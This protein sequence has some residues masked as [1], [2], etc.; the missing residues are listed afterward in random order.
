MNFVRRLIRLGLR[1]VGNALL[2]VL[3]LAGLAAAIVGYVWYTLP[4]VAELKDRFP[5]VTLQKKGEPVK[6]TIEAKRPAGWT[7]LGEIPRAV[8]GAVVVSEDGTFFQHDG[9]DTDAL[10]AAIKEDLERKSFAFGGSTITQQVVKN[11][12]LQKQKSLIRKAKEFYLA[13]QLD[14][15]ADKKRILEIYFNI[16][17]LGDGIYGIRQAAR[18]Y[19]QKPPSELT[20]KEGA[21][22]AMLLPSPKKYSVSFRKQ[23][24]TR[25]AQRTINSLLA[26]MAQAGYITA[27]ERDLW[28]STPLSFER[29]A[30]AEPAPV[31]EGDATQAAPEGAPGDSSED[32]TVVD[33]ESGEIE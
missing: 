21:F 31:G 14:K 4:P 9:Y 20:P 12:Y 13:I 22:I 27:D 26:R 16:V 3:L 33:E 29:A 8:V 18:H 11:V 32:E 19:F 10:K 2:G 5:V 25:F 7:S 6:V 23:E 24:L 17:E 1:L 30:L 28:K 15:A